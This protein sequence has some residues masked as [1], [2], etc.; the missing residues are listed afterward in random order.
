M[1]ITL[2][3]DISDNI[4]QRLTYLADRAG[5]EKNFYIMDILLEHIEKTN[6]ISLTDT[7]DRELLFQKNNKSLKGIWEGAGF[8]K[9][10]DLEE[11]IK[12]ARKKLQNGISYSNQF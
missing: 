9:I 1:S 4:N 12:S 3:V 11:E 6:D 10:V 2:S 7:I 5:K 8:E